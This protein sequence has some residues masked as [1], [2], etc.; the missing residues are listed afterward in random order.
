MAR[1]KKQKEKTAALVK[2]V[3]DRAVVL[4][5][6]S[7][8]HVD[9]YLKKRSGRIVGVRR[10]V[11]SWLLLAVLLCA[12]TLLALVQVFRATYVSSGT[13]GGIYTEGVV[14]KVNNLNPLFSSGAV[15]DSV[16]KLVFN[17]L[18]RYDTT[19]KL[20]PDIAEGWKVSDEGETYTITLRSDVR[21][22]D[23][24]PLTAEDVV[25]TI[26][27]IQNPQTRSVLFA[28]WQ[29]VNVVAKGEREV[30]FSLP[31][32]FAPFPNALTQPIL[33]KHLLGDMPAE[34]LRTA[35]YN[36]SPIGTGPFLFSVV[37]NDTVREQQVEVR[38]NPDYYRGEPKID[39][40]IVHGY[41]NDE[42]LY[43][44]LDR[45]EITAAVDLKG[46]LLANFEDDTS[47]RLA[48]MPL[49]S[50]VFA[51]FKTSQ[52]VFSDVKIRTALAEAIDRQAILALFNTRY[53]PLKTPLLPSQLGYD[54][55]FQQKTNRNAAEKKLDEAGW[56]KQENGTRAKDG[57]Q[58]ELNL[59][60]LSNPQYSVLAEELKKQWA[61]I[62]VS[63]RP[64][65]L[66]PEQLQQN[67]L[68]A[69][70]YDILLYGVS[71]GYDPDVFAYWHSSQ[72]RP[73]GLNFSEWKSA[74]ADVSLE[75]ARTRLDP[76]LREAR[77]KNFEDEW[78]KDSPAVALYQP[79]VSYAYHQNATGFEVFPLT[80]AS[81]RLT[82][83]EEWTVNTRLVERTP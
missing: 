77:Y 43:E 14:G 75:V 49:N 34:K 82:N 65:F 68:S 30:T 67:A 17:G 33:P 44:A 22:H 66:N 59:T 27:T 26:K 76:I 19:G 29:G 60:T 28:N 16:S 63:V 73:G 25:F 78:L 39:K 58:L 62:G 48:D 54:A 79:R 74:R 18:A 13:P 71:I 8:K 57:T 6:T 23:G 10:F 46:E 1:L 7:A 36:A 47:I 72:A 41:E 24:K 37:R 81:E 45:R 52:P 3:G 61:E 21:W 38:K 4:Q 35:A 9:K 51:F 80:H 53:A 70:S 69:H 5:G 64:Q 31:A 50:G 12:G 55:S 42:A 2:K 20:V 32:A 83:V 11:A 40:F 15:D 56:V